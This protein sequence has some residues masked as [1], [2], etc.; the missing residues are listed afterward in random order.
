VFLTTKKEDRSE[1]KRKLKNTC[2]AEKTAYN[3]L[4]GQ[5][6]ALAEMLKK[7]SASI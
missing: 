3:A 6:D 2:Q 4:L 7:P 1:A 5:G